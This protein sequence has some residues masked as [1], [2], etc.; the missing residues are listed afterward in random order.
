[1]RT[2]AAEELHSNP[3]RPVSP[4]QE[5]S[6]WVVPLRPEVDMAPVDFDKDKQYR[7]A[8][9]DGPSGEPILGLIPDE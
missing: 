8:V 2:M 4:R 6:S 1:M 5:H 7:W 3:S 9:V